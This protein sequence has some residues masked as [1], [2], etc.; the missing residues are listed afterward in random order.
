MVRPLGMP[1]RLEYVAGFSVLVWNLILYAI[2]WL[3]RG[4]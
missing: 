4:A 3:A 1:R 2:I